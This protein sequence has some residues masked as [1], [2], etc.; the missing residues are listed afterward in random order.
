MQHFKSLQ[1]KNLTIYN[2]YCPCRKIP[3]PKL[4]S[5]NRHTIA[6]AAETKIQHERKTN[7]SLTPATKYHGHGLSLTHRRRINLWS[8]P[9]QMKSHEQP[10]KLIVHHKLIN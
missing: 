7:D 3:A 8:H 1:I 9:R 5:Y 2:N 6:H 10:T 4:L